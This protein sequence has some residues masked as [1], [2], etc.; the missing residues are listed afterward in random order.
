MMSGDRSAGAFGWYSMRWVFLVLAGAAAIAAQVTVFD[1]L[2]IRGV[3]PDL[4]LAM[5]LLVALEA[6]RLDP[7]CVASWLMGLMVDLV[8]GARFGTNSLLFLFAALVA[9]GLKRIVAGE[10]L[11]GRFLVVGVIVLGVGAIEGMGGGLGLQGL[12]I[13]RLAVQVAGT[14]LYTAVLAPPMGWLGRPLLAEFGK[15]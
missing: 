9:F 4:A 2:A 1:H 15:A 5:A 12:G 7:A 10:T 6:R 3:R 14:A 13:N 8:S 11:V